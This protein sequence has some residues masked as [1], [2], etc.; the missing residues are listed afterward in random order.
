MGEVGGT[1]QSGQM[2][3]PIRTC[4]WH[5]NFQYC[6]LF[7]SKEPSN[8]ISLEQHALLSLEKASMPINIFSIK[9]KKKTEK[10]RKEA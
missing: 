7:A 4:G 1:G 5:P 6:P 2:G 9:R 8:V 10:E 3:R